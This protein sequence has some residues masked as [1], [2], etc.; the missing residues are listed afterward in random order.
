M[1]RDNA[2]IGRTAQAVG[3]GL[4]SWADA[5]HEFAK[6]VGILA[7]VTHNQAQANVVGGRLIYTA[8]GVS[9]YS[10]VLDRS[11]VAVAIEAKTSKANA[12][13]RANVKP[14]QQ[15][16]LEVVARA[17]G[18]ALLLVEWRL[19]TPPYR[20][21]AAIPWLEVPWAVKRSAE[22]LT[23]S[24]AEPWVIQPSTCYLERF[25]PRGVPTSKRHVKV[26]PRD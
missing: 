19:E 23:M 4:E 21:R 1:A 14:K 25:H 12:L 11:G 6:T 17:G 20:V 10:G 8:S 2:A 3:A 24:D 13:P 7:H 26:Y 18:L 9:D 5:Q 15:E 22:S 16:H